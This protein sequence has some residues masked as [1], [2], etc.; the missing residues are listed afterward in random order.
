[1]LQKRN[2][3]RTSNSLVNYEESKFKNNIVQKLGGEDHFQFLVIS[4]CERIRNDPLLKRSYKGLD[5]K[6]L[7]EL[8]KD[9]ILTSFLD[10]SP[11]EY[12]ILRSK[13]FLRHHVIFQE[14]VPEKHYEALEEN[15]VCAMRDVWVD[16]E[17]LEL[18][19]THFG[20]IRSFLEDCSFMT[21]TNRI[22]Q[23]AYINRVSFRMTGQVT[24]RY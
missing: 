22:E 10:V 14:G 20:V 1:M 16:E 3:F 9:M 15:F 5:E 7:I 6:G 11:S 21:Q 19:K 12:Q 2:I 8:Q 13:L 24:R 17:V 23:N 4:F 18:C